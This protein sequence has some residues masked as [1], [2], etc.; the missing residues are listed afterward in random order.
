MSGYSLGESSEKLRQG[1]HSSVS[2]S[3]T[4]S[5]DLTNTVTKT[6]Y[7]SDVNPRSMRRL[8][9]IVAITGKRH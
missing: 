8:M 3:Y 2:H 7:F 6:D 5:M 1:R 4:S 9:N